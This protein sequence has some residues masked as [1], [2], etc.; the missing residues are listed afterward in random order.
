MTNITRE[1][2]GWM[3]LET[4]G[5]GSARR[6]LLLPGLM[7]SDLVFGSLLAD[8]ALA[9]AGYR[10]VAGN[11]PGFKGLPVNRDFDFSI[12]SYA[13]L[14]EELAATEGFD[15]LVGHSYFANVLIEVAARGGY[16]GKLVL[17]SPSLDRAAEAKDLRDLDR[18]SRNP[19]LRAPIWWLTYLMMKSV[20]KP[21]FSDP[22]LLSEITAAAKLI[23]ATVARR[24][25]IGFFDHLD[26][27]GDLAARLATTRIPVRY[28]RGREDDI[29]FTAEHRATLATNP[30]VEIHEIPGARHFAMCDQPAAVGQHIMAMAG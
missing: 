29:G 12:E 27:H 26:K 13:A 8:P 15:V 11:P 19:V 20:F 28:L 22:V 24:T 1:Q 4:P 14:V 3:L 9:A 23:P 17:I 6:V 2:G 7:G 10:L 30:L 25:L 18:Y 5:G 16:R 21:Y